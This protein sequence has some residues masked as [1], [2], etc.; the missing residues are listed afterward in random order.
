MFFNKSKKLLIAKEQELEQALIKLT[1]HE[2]IL[3]KLA[4]YEQEFKSVIDKNALLSEKSGMVAEAEKKLQELND[5][6]QKGIALHKSLEEEIKLY[7]DSL[8]ISS[9]GLY[10]PQ[11]SFETSEKFKHELELNYEKQKQLIKTDN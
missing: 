3:T 9:Y 10:K 1:S 5:T 7:E 11:F 4:S 6:Y 2:E 8:E